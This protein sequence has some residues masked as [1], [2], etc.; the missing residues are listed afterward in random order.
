MNIDLHYSVKPLDTLDECFNAFLVP[1]ERFYYGKY[2]YKVTFKTPEYDAGILENFFGY[3]DNVAAN[4]Y[5]KLHLH[6]YLGIPREHNNANKPDYIEE[7]IITKLAA[8]L[9]EHIVY[10]KS[11]NDLKLALHSF[12]SA[13]NE[14]CGPLNNVHYELLLHKN[15][16]C[17]VRS[18]L[19]HNK[20]D[21]RV[22]IHLNKT[23]IARTANGLRCDPANTKKEIVNF[24]KENLGAN[25]LRVYG[26]NNFSRTIDLYTNSE[27]FDQVYP[28]LIM[29]YNDWRVVVTKAYI[30]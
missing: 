18:K 22:F 4:D 3:S 30:K 20:Y 8:S 11:L 5:F 2:A 23:A 29:M 15:F 21:Y 1:S 10:F 17:E 28:F 14:I 24:L 7:K 6:S 19:W 16:R 27:A 9:D 25:N 13:V 26:T 12:G